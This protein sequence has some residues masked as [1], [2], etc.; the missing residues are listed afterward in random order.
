MDFKKTVK[1]KKIWVREE[2]L[3]NIPAI[4]KKEYQLLQ[5][6]VQN[7]D[8]C[9]ALF[10]LKD[11]YEICIKLP[12]I[13]SIIT[14]S[15]RMERDRAF[16]R[17]P[18][19]QL[20]KEQE[21]FLTG[22]EAPESDSEQQEKFRYILSHMVKEP[23]SIGS[24]RQITSSIVENAGIFALDKDLKEIL[25]RTLLLFQ[26]KP[27]K[28]REQGRYEDVGNWRNKTIGHGTLFI[29]TEA[30][31]E[32][33]YDLVQGLFLYFGGNGNTPLK[34]FYGRIF[35]EK[36]NDGSNVLKVGEQTY[37]ISE[38]I[39][40][41]EEKDYF[42]DS[43]YSRQ[44][45]AEI[46]NY[47][48]APRRLKNNPYYENIYSMLD[49][50]KK[51]QRR[52]KE[53]QITKSS[54]REAYACLNCAPGYEKPEFVLDEIRT[55]M[56]EHDRGVLHIQMER[57]MGKSTL[58][59]ELDGRY[60]RGI[61]QED[62]KAVV[63]VYH[64]R[65]M[66]FREENPARDFF[67]ALSSNL[68]SFAGGQLE[69][70]NE[71]YYIDGK[72]IRQQMEHGGDDAPAAFCQ[73]LELFRERYEEE[74]TDHEGT[75]EEL[76]LV[77]ILDG[78]DELG[79]NAGS[80]LDAIPDP[81]FLNA[82]P[83]ENHIYLILLSR[84]QDEEDLQGMAR[85]WIREAEKKAGRI[86]R[87]DGG[88]ECYLALLKKYL[89]KNYK[90]L[91]DEQANDIIEKA[92]RKFLYI[93]PYLARG[94]SVLKADTKITAYDVAANYMEKLQKRYCGTSLHTLQLI[95]AAIAVFGSATLREICEL[96]LFTG[97]SYDV[98][99]VLNDI[100]PLLTVKRAAGENWYEFAN[101]AYGQYIFE[102]LSEAAEE[103]VCRYRISLVSWFQTA[104]WR[105]DDYGKQWGEYVRRALSV[106]GAAR[107]MGFGETTEEYVKSLIRMNY[108]RGPQ[109]YYASQIYEELKCDILRQIILLDYRKL[110][111][112]SV[113]DLKKIEFQFKKREPWTRKSI[114]LSYEYTQGLIS[115]CMEHGSVDEWFQALTMD[116]IN[117]R[118]DFS[119]NFDELKL[120]AFR[121]IVGAWE[122]Q[123]SAAVLFT[124]LVEQD[125]KNQRGLFFRASYGTYLEQLLLVVQNEVLRNKIF[126]GLLEAYDMLAE[127]I[128][129]RPEH[130]K[131]DQSR[132][133]TML[134][135]LEMAEQKNDLENYELI[136]KIKKVLFQESIADRTIVQLEELAENIASLEPTE[137]IEK[138]FFLSLKECD[139][140]EEQLKQYQIATI[141]NYTKLMAHL[142]KLY[143][144]QN[145]DVVYPWLKE[146]WFRKSFNFFPPESW[147]LL[148]EYLELFDQII[149]SYGKENN[150][151]HIG[152]LG[153]AFLTFLQY[154]DK[155]VRK[156]S[157]GLYPD[158]IEEEKVDRRQKM[159]F[160]EKTYALYCSSSEFFTKKDANKGIPIIVN[161]FTKK[162]LEELYEDQNL[163][164]YYDLN[165][166]IEEGY[167]SVHF[168]ENYRDFQ[169]RCIQDYYNWICVRY[170]RSL[171]KKDRRPSEELFRCLEC[172]YTCLLEKVMEMLKS[173]TDFIHKSAILVE[174]ITF[175]RELIR[176]AEM[177]PDEI[178]TA[179]ETKRALLDKLEELAEKAEELGTIKK[180]TEEIEWSWR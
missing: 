76:K 7:D 88:N 79:S 81:V 161:H 162:Y 119:T 137:Y 148:V 62:L 155:N 34:E 50:R 111:I 102:S 2:E 45:Y 68:S 179:E 33:V 100:L 83:E 101:E 156:K 152:K 35:I 42:F 59:H 13:L 151:D 117:L 52:K 91:S 180:V 108:D 78:I 12:S 168:R 25:E 63:R 36:E 24:W 135:I 77:Y 104:D 130:G 146:W 51:S 6:S 103:A 149:K 174:V 95:S 165:S 19:T 159:T 122:D 72:D 116:R 97:I 71:D 64:I 54:D 89:Q 11:I 157:I 21:D 60:Q 9:G 128:L 126:E 10:R 125:R 141:R 20:K 112:L 150:V 178:A 28:V 113:D 121:E 105:K 123:E 27:R 4:L 115:H 98:V 173:E 58:A 44:K 18:E 94:D 172:E 16:V 127:D 133:K 48:D 143:Q 170:S 118:Y 136:S 17:M 131:I 175:S 163:E 147:E 129:Q 139:L 154:Y 84:I 40:T 176:L 99:G 82:L 73:Y 167:A 85:E 15:A 90:K 114:R 124:N 169:V 1:D 66:Q 22:R 8:I 86:V 14:I 110:Q 39:Y 23:L 120:A 80:V 96:V 142:K 107:W 47:L 53:R 109:T 69:M 57:G 144:E 153:H 93:R 140:T 134:H 171:E 37:P 74:L 41:F 30:Y 38:Y 158:Y 177:V 106:D 26:V 160:W 138:L 87:F 46:T 67:T 55:F 145:A 49:G 43:Y 75:E 31:W 92:Q 164:A 5:Q 70:D 32:Q 56:E 29:N 166:K 65:D 3:Q 132:K 61:L